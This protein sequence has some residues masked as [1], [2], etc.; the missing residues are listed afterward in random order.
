MS[1]VET[2]GR[3]GKITSRQMQAM[4][5]ISAQAVHKEMKKLLDQKVV[6]LVGKGRAAHYELN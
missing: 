1:I 6:R 4:F 2:I 5:K 3:S